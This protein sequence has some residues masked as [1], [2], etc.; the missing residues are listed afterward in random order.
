MKQQRH[1]DT[2]ETARRETALIRKMIGE[3]DRSLELLNADIA[4]EENRVW[5]F[6]QSDAAYPILVASAN[7]YRAM[8][9]LQLAQ[10]GRE[11]SKRGFAASGLPAGRG[12][13]DLTEAAPAVVIVWPVSS[14][15][16]D[17]QRSDKIALANNE[18]DAVEQASIASQCS[19]RFQLGHPLHTDANRQHPSSLGRRLLRAQ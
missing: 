14:P 3:L 11:V 12:G 10:E 8:T 13:S 16:G 6:D 1:I 2:D 5:I 17:K 19:I 4:A 7:A 18:M 15:A 9:C